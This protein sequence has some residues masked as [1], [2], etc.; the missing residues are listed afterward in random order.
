LQGATGVGSQGAT[1]STGPMGASGIG[2]QG[3]T[4]AT[5]ATGFGATGATGGIGAT[6]EL[7][8]TGATGLG[9]TGASG[10]SPVITRQS[11]TTHPIQ[12]GTK[13]F[14]YTSAPIGWTYGSRLRAVANSAY[15]YDWV[16]GTAIQVASNFV[17]IYIDKFQGSGTFSDWQIALSG[18][19]GIGATGS[20]GPIGATG[21]TGPQGSTG[22]GTTGATGVQ[23]PEGSTGATGLQGATGLGATGATGV[24]GATGL[25]GQSASFYNYQ[26]DAVNVSGVP[27]NGLIIWNNLTQ[28]SATTVTLSHIDAL[29]ND[30]DV[31]FPLFKTGDKFVVQDQGNSANFQTWEISATPTVVLNSY[32]T[33][34]VTLVTSGGTSQFIDAQNLIFAIVSSGLVGATGATGLQGATGATGLTGGQGATGTT[35]IQGIQGL[36]GST[37]ATGLTGGQGSTGSA[38]ITGATGATGVQGVQGI[39]GLT[40]STGATGLTGPVAGSANQVVYK[41]SSN[42]PTGSPNF[43]FNGTDLSAP[44]FTSTNSSGAEGGQ[45]NLERPQSAT[46]LDG[47]VAIDVF[48][49]LVRIFESGGAY[50]GVYLDLTQTISGVGTNLLPTSNAGNVWTFTGNGSTTTWTLTGNT[51][52]SLVSALYLVHID[53]VVQPPANYTIN[54]ASPRTLTISTVPSGSTLVV[55]SLSTA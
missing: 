24:Q 53:G 48:A 54:N 35:G 23:G 5:G 21:S 19:G 12:V 39:Q 44:Y 8:A 3:L 55:V 47:P 52:G 22:A 6:G 16:E 45:I 9:A 43:T 17:T 32:V 14:Y 42:N 20:T 10:I 51:S 41:N 36:T 33:I 27:A 37:G 30:I 2:T 7:G 40:G 38:G 34:P 25:P 18:D 26:A 31:F 15:P 46:N 11:S 50:R 29:G 49:N 1:G 13:T 4:G 28:V